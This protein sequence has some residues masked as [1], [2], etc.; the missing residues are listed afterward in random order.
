MQRVVEGR[1]KVGEVEKLLGCLPLGPQLESIFVGLSRHPSAWHRCR[2]KLLPYLRIRRLNASTN[3][4]TGA[5]F[6]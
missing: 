3:V 5:Y 4:Y 1:P 2:V 6:K